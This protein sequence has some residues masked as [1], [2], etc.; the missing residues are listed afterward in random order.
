MKNKLGSL[1]TYM[2][3]IGVFIFGFAYLLKPSFMPYHA[4]AVGMPWEDVPYNFQ[5]LIWTY[6]K[7]ASGGWIALGLV[8]SFLQFKF[9]QNKEVWIPF[10]L[11][12]GG[13]IFAATFW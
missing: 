3:M 7:A 1:L 12:V 2:S 10:L 9:N 4:E 8:F 6:M 11:L 13:L 5:R